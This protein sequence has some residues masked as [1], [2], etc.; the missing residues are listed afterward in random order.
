MYQAWGEL[1]KRMSGGVQHTLVHPCSMKKTI[2]AE[3]MPNNITT[4]ELF[5]LL[6]MKQK[7]IAKRLNISLLPNDR[8]SGM[9]GQSALFEILRNKRFDFKSYLDGFYEKWER[10]HE[11]GYLLAFMLGYLYYLRRIFECPPVDLVR[12]LIEPVTSY[13]LAISWDENWET[14]IKMNIFSVTP[15]NESNKQIH[16]ILRH[17]LPLQD[18][19]GVTA[20]RVKKWLGVSRA[21]ASHLVE[22]M[23]SSWMEHWYRIVSKNTGTV[24]ILTKSQASSKV[25]PSLYSSCTSLMDDKEYFLSVREV[26]KK[27]AEDKYFEMEA[28][29]TN[30]DLFDQKEKVWKL[31]ATTETARMPKDIYSLFQNSDLTVPDN[32]IP[33]TRKDFLFIALLAGMDTGHHPKKRQEI[34]KY[35]TEGYGVPKKDVVNGIRNVFRKNMVRNQYTHH[36]FTDLDREMYNITF[37]DQSKKVIP[38]LGEILPNLPFSI[39]YTDAK[40]SYG[41]IFEYH[42]S[43]LSCD[44]RKLIHSSMREHD[45]DGELF[46]VRSW[47]YGEPGS[48]LQLVPDE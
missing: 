42:P 8:P 16:M 33:P 43:Y 15:P 5:E 17:L 26:H 30:V 9:L 21:E 3:L 28:W 40:M 34:L 29:T 45:V 48:L 37:N 6:P 38:F 32:D 27:D 44:V 35:F 11:E 41:Y 14:R 46:V 23:R 7:E 19:W 24:K 18:G 39:F 2:L 31:S 47:G 36:G 25:V 12:C 22:I 10:S 20:N 13:Q 4:K 1:T